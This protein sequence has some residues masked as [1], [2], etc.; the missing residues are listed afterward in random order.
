MKQRYVFYI[1]IANEERPDL[2]Y[3]VKFVVYRD[4]FKDWYYSGPVK[5]GRLYTTP[6]DA[7]QY[8]TQFA[9]TNKKRF[10]IRLREGIIPWRGSR[11]NEQVW[12]EATIV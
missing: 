11:V 9:K 8:I 6:E 1:T 10:D 7:L 4:T 5:N 2:G 12:E 3:H